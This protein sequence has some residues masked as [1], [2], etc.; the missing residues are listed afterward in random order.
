MRIKTL[1]LYNFRSFEHFETSFSDGINILYGKNAI[2]KT[3]ILEAINYLSISKSF[4]TN[5]FITYVED[6][7]FWIISGIITLYFIFFFNNGELRL[8][9]FLGIFTGIILYILTISKYFI[10]INVT[11]IKFVKK[12]VKVLINI[13]K[14]PF[15]LIMNIIKKIFFKPV[16][17]INI[18]IRKFYINIYSYLLKKCKN[19]KKNKT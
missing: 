12:I 19:I 15:I 6:S 10:K 9:I 8:Y 16:S 1:K 7:L 4:K 18:N 3:T 5:D 2:G 11:I 13:I 17:I 14:Y